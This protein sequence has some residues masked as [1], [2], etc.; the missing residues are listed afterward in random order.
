VLEIVECS[1]TAG[2]LLLLLLLLR[3]WLGARNSPNLRATDYE[4][5]GLDY[6]IWLRLGFEV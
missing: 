3:L 6:L 4:F 5:Y 2:L 1:L